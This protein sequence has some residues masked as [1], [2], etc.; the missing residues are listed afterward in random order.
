MKKRIAVVIFALIIVL[1]FVSCGNSKSDGQN[2]NY[3][4][5][6]RAQE[7]GYS[8]SVGTKLEGIDN[9]GNVET[10]TG[11]EEGDS[12]FKTKSS[13]ESNRKLIKSVDISAESLDFDN[14]ISS[15]NKEIKNC[16]GYIEQS[17]MSG[18][19][20][21]ED[22]LRYASFDIRIPADKMDEFLNGVN[23]LCNV[24]QKSES[25]RDETS[26]YVDT[27]S[28]LNALRAE[29][30][31]LLSLLKQATRVEDIISLQSRLTEVIYQIESYEGILRTIDDLVDYSTVSIYISE[32]EKETSTERAKTW[33]EKMSESFKNGLSDISE[34]F[35][36]FSVAF[37]GVLPAILLLLI[38][39]IIV[40]IIILIV[41][42]RGKRKNQ[43]SK[44][45]ATVSQTQIPASANQTDNSENKLN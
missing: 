27:E 14:A 45:G 15:L 23:E 17:E 43:K 1:S 24:T 29:E 42:R 3:G 7:S 8:N 9:Y 41:R 37:M 32:V 35:K 5:S 31:S 22:S 40:L 4:M 30:E 28:H 11:S 6:D 26:S 39:A 18:N 21:D 34:G 38:L 10:M 25:V 12:A 20:Y 33:G 16:G 36:N 13:E 44:I 2:S 19:A